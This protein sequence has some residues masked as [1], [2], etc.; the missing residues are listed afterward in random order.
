MIRVSLRYIS[1][2]SVITGRKQEAFFVAEGTTLRSLLNKVAEKYGSA[3][4]REVFDPSGDEINPHI[5]VLV[6]GLQV[7]QLERKLDTRLLHGDSVILTPP[8]SGG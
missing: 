7:S 8:M 4:K 2:Y 3:L 1:S 6:N 5:L